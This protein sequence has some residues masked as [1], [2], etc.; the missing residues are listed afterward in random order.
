MTFKSLIPGTVKWRHYWSEHPEQQEEMLA[1]SKV[2]VLVIDCYN[3]CYAALYTT[4]DLTWDDME[5]GT[6]FG[7]LRQVF[8]I[9][10]KFKTGKLVFCWDSRKSYR[11]LI[12]PEYK[13]DRNLDLIEEEALKLK[14]AKK[15]IDELRTKI[16]P[17]FGFKNSFICTGYEADDLIAYTV[18]KCL[19]TVVVS[20]DSDLWQLLDSTSIYNQCAKK[21]ITKDGFEKEHGI[22]PSRWKDVIA[23]MGSHN[24]VTG[25]DG[26][27]PVTAVKY[28]RGELSDGV[29]KKSIETPEA[30]ELVRRNLKLIT[31]PLVLTDEYGKV[32]VELDFNEILYFD[33]F[34]DIFETYGFTSMLNQ[35]YLHGLKRVF[36]LKS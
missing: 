20:A 8:S 2:P 23:L 14:L 1:W 17:A 10:K 36:G 24:N 4:G 15:Q 19:N 9:A 26:I 32:G 30:Q 13:G 28:L 18:T 27:G 35:D 22:E 21:M 5:T 34:V 16:I 29:K 33:A 3:L 7:F 31:L 11:K 25:I 12:Y 6:S